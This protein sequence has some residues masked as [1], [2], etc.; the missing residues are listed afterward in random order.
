M[1]RV[2]LVREGGGGRRPSGGPRGRQR[3]WGVRSTWACI[4]VDTCSQAR[5]RQDVGAS[6]LVL[7]LCPPPSPSLALSLSLSLALSLSLSLS[8]SLPLSL[9]L[10]RSLSLQ[11]GG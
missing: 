9:S 7:S 6:N 2:Q 8:P 11:V 10:A 5:D 4:Y 1:R 3:R